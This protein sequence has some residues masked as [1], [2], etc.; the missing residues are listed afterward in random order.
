MGGARR[1]PTGL[2]VALACAGSAAPPQAHAKKSA[3][4][5]DGPYTMSDAACEKLQ[6][7]AAGGPKSINT[8]PWSVARGGISYWEGGCSFSRIV[9]RQKGKVWDVTASCT[10]GPDTST[11][12]YTF[13]RAGDGA[14]DV[15]LKGE[16]HAR[17]YTRCDVTKRK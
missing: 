9:E 5:L 8:V 11:E 10:E 17:R 15:K 13:A 7:L 2:L 3:A 1:L 14:F 6:A 16:K 12:R 4:F